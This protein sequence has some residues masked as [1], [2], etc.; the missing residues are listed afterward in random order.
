MIKGT[1]FIKLVKSVA[2]LA[3]HQL[4]FATNTIRKRK[5]RFLVL[6]PSVFSN[7]TILD[8]AL[9][10]LIKIRI[11][12]GTDYSTLMQIYGRDGY[13]LSKLQ[14]RPDIEGFY[15][16]TL[17][18]GLVPLI[19][20]CGGHIGMA[21]RYFSETYPKARVV[22]VEPDAGNIAQAR[23]NNAGSGIAFLNM[24]IGSETG[25]GTLVDPGRGNNAF[26]ITPDM[27]GKTPITSINALLEQFGG[28]TGVPFIVKIDIEGFE[29]DLFSKNLEWLDQ[30]PLLVIELHDWM[31]PR[32]GNAGNFL[33]A[34]S[35]LDRDFVYFEE[36]VFSISNRLI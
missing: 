23:I 32:S 33:R 25:A 34:I 26:R 30:F 9:K 11:S 7:Q 36:N 1:T 4:K 5:P 14:R 10:R 21:S 2:D 22:S 16:A 15:A 19:L 12:T 18:R 8:T 13:G 31:L 35:A 20:D 27:Q 28:E 17:G 29:S 24:A 6:T 3:I